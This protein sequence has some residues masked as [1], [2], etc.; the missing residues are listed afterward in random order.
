MLQDLKL[1]TPF[2]VEDIHRTVVAS[3][4]HR[5]EIIT[6]RYVFW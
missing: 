3:T 1:H 5:F 4:H 2:P 6:E